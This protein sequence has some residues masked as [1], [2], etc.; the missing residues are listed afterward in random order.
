MI[1]SMNID[2]YDEV[3]GLWLTANGVGLNNLDDSREGIARFLERNPQTCYV[4]TEEDRI[5]GVILSGNDGRRGYIY[6]LA[7]AS[8]YRHRG[9][10]RCLV[11]EVMDALKGLGI[12]K[13][14]LVIFTGNDDANAFWEKMGF[15]Q[16]EDIN[17]RNKLINEM[18]RYD[19]GED[20]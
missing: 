5:I 12:N 15:E 18:I 3:Y 7:V 14:A 13:A 9:I 4:A 10:G 11:D 16:R 1:R 19:I 17:Y 20:K 2:D 6:H 8:E